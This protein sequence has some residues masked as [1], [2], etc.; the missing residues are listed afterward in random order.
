MRGVD[1]PAQITLRLPIGRN[2]AKNR[3]RLLAYILKVFITAPWPQ[4]V[5]TLPLRISL[6]QTSQADGLVVLRWLALSLCKAAPPDFAS[7]FVLAA[8][9]RFGSYANGPP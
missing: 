4:N 5:F 9:F 7:L 6:Q 1:V 2:T 8:R 3:M